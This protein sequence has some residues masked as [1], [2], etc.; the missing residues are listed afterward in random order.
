[1]IVAFPSGV[2][3]SVVIVWPSLICVVGMCMPMLFSSK[4]SCIFLYRGLPMCLS[5]LS[6]A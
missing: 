1:M 2:F 4:F 3:W 5:S 6:M